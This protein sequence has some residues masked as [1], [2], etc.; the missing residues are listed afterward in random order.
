MPF[1]SSFDLEEV[2]FLVTLILVSFKKPHTNGDI[3]RVVLGYHLTRKFQE[4]KILKD[5]NVLKYKRSY[6]IS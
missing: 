6:N 1:S 2:K 4:H 5:K 3:W